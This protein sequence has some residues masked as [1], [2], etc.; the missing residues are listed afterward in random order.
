MKQSPIVVV[1]TGQCGFKAIETLRHSGYHDQ[2][3]FIGDEQYIPY[4]RPPLSKAFLR[5]DI[6]EHSMKLTSPVFFDDF[7]IE[8]LF[9]TK[10]TSMDANAHTIYLDNGERLHYSK[11]LLALGSRPRT[12][13]IPGASLEGVHFLRTLD[14]AKFLSA[15]LN[16]GDHTIL[17]IGGGYTGLEVAA[18][19]RMRGHNITLIES[20]DRILSRVVSPSVS[21]FFE[22]LHNHHGVRILKCTIPTCFLG[23]QRISAVELSSGEIIECDTILVCIGNVPEVGLAISAGLEVGDGI[24]VN[25]FCQTSATDVF[26]AGDCASFPSWRYGRNIRLESVQN[27]IDQGK[28]ASNAMLGKPTHYDPLPWFWSNQYNVRLQIAGLSN[29]Y[30]RMEIE[31]GKHPGRFSVQYFRAGQMICTDSINNTRAYMQARQSLELSLQYR[32]ERNISSD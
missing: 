9:S 5:G 11:L 12:L 1:G 29:G 24:R 3:I 27:A 31:K 17:I 30:E 7:E 32:T 10:V 21:Y 13:D 18:S 26:A 25:T 22:D 8:T 14:D 4:Q 20:S 19:L 28:A 6:A 16:S 23:D 15:E 2:L